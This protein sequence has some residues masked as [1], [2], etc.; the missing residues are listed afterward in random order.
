[1]MT[2]KK[3]AHKQSVK[4]MLNNQHGCQKSIAIEKKQFEREHH[5]AKMHQF[6]ALLQNL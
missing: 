4:L 6:T 1:M 3:D 5:L 2:G